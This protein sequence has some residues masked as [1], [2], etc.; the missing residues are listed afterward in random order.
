MTNTSASAPAEPPNRQAPTPETPTPETPTPETPTS[1]AGRRELAR[2]RLTRAQVVLADLDGCLAKGN[3]PLPGADALARALGD[4]LY[5]V[6]NNSTDLADNL[7]ELLTSR[8]LAVPAQRI[9]LAGQ[10]AVETLAQQRPRA[11]VLLVAGSRLIALARRLEIQLV[12]EN[13][14]VV[15]LA[16]DPAF[17]YDKLQR[18]ARALAQGADLLAAN[19]DL[20]HP[21]ADGYPVPETGALLAAVRACAPTLPPARLEII[22][23]PAPAL[24]LAALAR[25]G[26]PAP[27]QAVMLGDNPLTDLAGATALGLPAILLG[28]HADALVPGVEQLLSF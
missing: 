2:Q 28:P 5:I 4:R 17:S 14:D 27:D 18:V 23:K 12:A 1:A 21:G 24:Y 19:P 8:G 26:N 15:L 25:A 7:S 11:R 6:S 9:L 3:C 10:L 13:P 20:T 22:G 16:R